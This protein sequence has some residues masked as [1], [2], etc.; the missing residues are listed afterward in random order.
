M[1]EESKILSMPLEGMYPLTKT[2][3]MM[4]RDCIVKELMSDQEPVVEEPPVVPPVVDVVEVEEVSEEGKE[5]P[6]SH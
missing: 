1:V 2:W 6:S 3:Y 5:V 4:I